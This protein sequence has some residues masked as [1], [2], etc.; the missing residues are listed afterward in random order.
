VSGRYDYDDWPRVDMTLEQYGW[1]C[2]LINRKD[3]EYLMDVGKPTP[4][5]AS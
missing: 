2:S 1:L 5:D 3:D 4:E